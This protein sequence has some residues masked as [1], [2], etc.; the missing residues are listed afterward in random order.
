MR[1]KRL[2][3]APDGKSY[4]LREADWNIG[5]KVYRSDRY[6][7]VQGDPQRC[8]IALGIKRDKDV[9]DVFIGSGKDAY[10]VFKGKGKP[11]AVHFVLTKTATSLLDAFDKD[12]S[13]ATKQIFL[14]K[15]TPGRTLAARR[16][17]NKDRNRRIKN[18]EHKVKHRG[19]NISRLTRLG[20]HH[21]P[22]PRTFTS[23]SVSALNPADAA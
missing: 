19:P 13:A 4:P 10:V 8:L 3:Q 23:G 17:M 14:R 20:V 22:H 5:F 18:G 7:A 21:R 12:R 9:L 16:K 2:Y 6:K 1:K 15:P 11:F